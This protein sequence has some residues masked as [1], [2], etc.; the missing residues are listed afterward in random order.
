MLFVVSRN[1]KGQTLVKNIPSK[2]AFKS[3]DGGDVKFS[4]AFL[5]GY[6]GGLPK[7]FN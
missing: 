7:G 4:E 5:R 3:L 2:K 1:N 6:L